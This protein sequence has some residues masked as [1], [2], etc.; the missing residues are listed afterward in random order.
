MPKLT[1]PI[2]SVATGTWVSDSVIRPPAAVRRRQQSGS[3]G[4]NSPASSR[5]C[6]TRATGSR[7]IAQRSCDTSSSDSDYAY[8]SAAVS[9]RPIRV[10]F[11]CFV[12]RAGKLEDDFKELFNFTHQQQAQT[13]PLV[14]VPPSGA[15]TCEHFQIPRTHMACAVATKETASP[16]TQIMV[17]II[18]FWRS[19]SPAG[20][21]P[22]SA[23]RAIG[24]D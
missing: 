24:D 17:N 14:G 7:S 15:V 6:E 9:I 13:N 11:N 3:S 21:R 20:C 10:Y 8:R 5:P 12:S 19:T 1:L 16:T 23:G 22:N 4:S 18:V 2:A